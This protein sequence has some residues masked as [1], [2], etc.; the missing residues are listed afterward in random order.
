MAYESLPL[1]R[2]Q[3]LHEAAGRALEALYA[4]RLTEATDRLAYH[5]SKTQ[6]AEKA[7]EYLKRFAEKAA[8]GH[9]HVEAI[10]ALEQALAHAE[11]LP[12]EERDGHLLDL[13][14]RQAYSLVP[15]GRFPD[16][17]ALLLRQQERLEALQDPSVAGNYYFLLGRTF[18]YLG[19][20]ER[21]A[22][23]AERAIAEAKRCG[24]EATM[25]KAYYL[26]AQQCPLAGRALQGIEHGRQAVALLERTGEQWWIG[27]A[28]WIVGL[29]Y[30]QMGEFEQALEAE[31]R[32]SAIG[33]AIGDP[34][35]QT[36]TAWATGIIHAAMGEWDAGIAA[37]QGGLEHSPDPLNTAMA[38]GWLGFA[39]LEK[40]EAARAIPLL[41]QSVRQLSQFRFPQFQGW[42]MVF[43]AEAYCATGEIQTAHQLA[44]QA[45]HITQAAGFS[46]GVALAKRAL[47]RI[48]GAKGLPDEAET[49]LSEALPIFS[50]HQAR[51]DLGRTHL[52]LATVT[53]AQGKHAEA[54]THLR[55]AH[56]LF[57]SLRIPKYVERTERLANTF[58]VVL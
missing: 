36:S 17:L 13:T 31:A 16:V 29:N 22:Q 40:G 47:G 24:D 51:Y 42:F 12:A 52:D 20:N 55:E 3:A 25:G 35:L 4:D 44:I 38:S 37:C 58:E 30:A 54:A 10:A 23:S 27:P 57:T 11:R 5:Y 53:D 26:L 19:D 39:F 33:D 56:R 50:S 48:A 2:R 7:V 46:Y 45:L 6:S 43:L 21:A 41:E 15:L 14:L 18:L 34:Q 49:Y 9:A 1:S 28:H 32:A 8:R